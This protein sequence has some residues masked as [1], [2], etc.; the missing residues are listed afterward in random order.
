MFLILGTESAENGHPSWNMVSW[1]GL[2]SHK[3]FLGMKHGGSSCT[4]PTAR[5]VWPR[6]YACNGCWL[7][8]ELCSGGSS[9]AGNMQGVMQVDSRWLCVRMVQGATSQHTTSLHN[10]LGSQNC[11]EV[12]TEVLKRRWESFMEWKHPISNKRSWLRIPVPCDIVQ[13]WSRCGGNVLPMYHRT[14][15]CTHWLQPFQTTQEGLWRKNLLMW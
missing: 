3:V 11:W 13:L 4:L 7:L 9:T 10:I 15:L 6:H 2:C 14:E 12:G 1:L 5:C 8:T